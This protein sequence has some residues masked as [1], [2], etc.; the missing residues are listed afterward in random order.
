MAGDTNI[1]KRL[2]ELAGKLDDEA[3]TT[4]AN[5]GLLRRARKEMEKGPAVKII[6]TG[7]DSLRISVADFVVS[8][9][10]SG[11]SK[12]ACTCSSSGSCW[13]IILAFLSLGNLGGAQVPQTNAHTTTEDEWLVLTEEQ[14][15]KWAGAEAYRKAFRLS[16]ENVES[17]DFPDVLFSGDIKC[18]L[19]AGAGLDGVLSNAPP[20]LRQTYAVATVL[21]YRRANGVEIAPAPFS[22]ASPAELN[23]GL[24]RKVQ[25]LL[26][27]SVEAGLNHLSLS[28]LQRM[29]SL[30]V[31]CRAEGLVRPCL[32]LESC[33]TE[34]E[35]V[36]ARHARADLPGLFDKMARL[37]GLTESICNQGGAATGEYT[38]AHRAKYES[39]GT[40][41]L[42]GLGTYP[43]ETESGFIGLTALFWSPSRQA[44]FSWSDSRPKHS[45]AGFTPAKRL[46]EEAPWT[47][48]GRLQT[49][50]RT[51]F[52]LEN[53]KSSPEGRLSA[54]NGCRATDCSSQL[55]SQALPPAFSL[56]S[57]LREAQARKRVVGLRR[58]GP[59]E[60][61]V[62][63]QAKKWHRPHFDE[64]EQRLTIPVE[65]TK[66]EVL[67]ILVPF[68]ELTAPAICF[69]ESYRANCKSVSVI[70]HYRMKPLEN[71]F[72][73]S[74]V[75]EARD[76][77]ISDIFFKTLPDTKT[78]WLGFLKKR[79]RKFVPS[80]LYQGE[81]QLSFCLE[82]KDPVALFLSPVD[83]YLLQLAE[84]GSGMIW[85]GIPPP[86][87]DLSGVGF[88][89]LAS[90]LKTLANARDVLITRYCYLLILE[91]L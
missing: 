70:G 62:R 35:R 71:V 47:G 56:W 14:L 57:E 50:S 74:L 9:D 65:D 15:R 86:D 75:E 17:S 85:T 4:Y 69:L 24:L 79:M 44:Y 29:Q 16:S 13:H 51:S 61:V 53:P 20:R 38:G 63:I 73:V 6:E 36:L 27:S 54:H 76:I 66:G 28:T 40:L 31:R 68:S 60:A 41:D 12:A 21:A 32:E 78:T 64:A 88:I 55:D 43:W 8:M 90:R 10:V 39:G 19:V 1:L 25:S 3:Y 77:E 26:E 52:R 23:L 67:L 33:A 18:R 42:T 5:K 58:E 82:S 83:D 11:I 59:L 81:G 91:A 89:Q 30:S 84:S 49:L 72:P 34:M 46:E 37:Y 48:G 80:S 7:P 2:V 45:M 87:V 22:D